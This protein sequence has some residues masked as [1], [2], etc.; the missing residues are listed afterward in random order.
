MG[1]NI[2][3]IT[4][5]AT[6][7]ESLTAGNPPATAADNYASQI[8]KLIPTEIVGVYLGLQN[9]FFSVA[10]PARVIAQSVVF[11]AILAVTPL[12]LRNAAGIT[13][14]KQRMVAICSY[15]IWSISL[16][17]PFE[18]LFKQ[19]KSPISAQMIGGALIMFY[20]LVVPLL[21]KKLPGQTS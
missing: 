4:P 12:Y 2:I 18:Y 14:A 19:I 16:G 13:D 20:T 21:Y 8:V 11:V 3:T 6:A 1:R 7:P 17:G 9:L 15:C 10:D 5:R